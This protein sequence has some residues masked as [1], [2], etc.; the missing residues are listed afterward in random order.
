LRLRRSRLLRLAGL[1]LVGGFAALA[2][3]RV[4]LGELWAAMLSASPAMLLAAGASNVLSQ[5]VRAARWAAVVRPPGVVLR[6]RHAFA[7][8]V[9]GYAVAVVVPA[10]AG[11]LVRSHMLARRTGLPKPTV[12]RLTQTLTVLGYLLS[13]LLRAVNVMV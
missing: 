2:A 11:D 8:L 7:P 9:A 6:A 3:Q 10:R 5:W 4:D 13:Y 1:A 12:S